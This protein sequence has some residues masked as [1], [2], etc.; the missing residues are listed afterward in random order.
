[1]SKTGHIPQIAAKEGVTIQVLQC[2]G[3]ALIVRECH[4]AVGERLA[5]GIIA[6]DL[7]IDNGAILGKEAFEVGF[8]AEL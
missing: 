8:G 1:M 3:G 4:E 7:D 5:G 6:F 2:G